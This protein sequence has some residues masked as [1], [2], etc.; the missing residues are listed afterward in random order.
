M[1]NSRQG[2]S[3]AHEALVSSSQTSSKTNITCC[4]VPDTPPKFTQVC[5]CTGT[6]RSRTKAAATGEDHATKRREGQSHPPLQGKPFDLWTHH[7]TTSPLLE[8]CTETWL[9]PSAPE[10]FKVVTKSPASPASK[11]V[12]CTLPNTPG[13]IMSLT[14]Q[15]MWTI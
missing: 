3:A 11:A 7:F 10:L 4:T 14:K 1:T 2:I 8:G 15:Q 5:F 12:P 13:D 6:W 9:L